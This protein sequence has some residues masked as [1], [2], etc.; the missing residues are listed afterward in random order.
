MLAQPSA[1]TAEELD[2][3]ELQLRKQRRIVIYV[4]DRPR[5]AVTGIELLSPGNKQP[6]AV[7]QQRYLEKRASALHGGLHWV[8]IDLLRGGVRPP[9]PVPPPQSADYLTYV[10]QATPTGWNHLL[11]AWT[12]RD[13]LPLLPIRLLGEDQVQ[14][15]LGRCFAVAYDRIAADDDVDYK[16]AP[17]PPPLRRSDAAWMGRLLRE[18]G[19]RKNKPRSG[20][21]R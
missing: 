20:R 1:S 4:Q 2:A 10:A 8:E 11:Y 21:K 17:P 9:M 19:L 5:L 14:L 16:T 13:P 7:A 18:R 6:G 12:L 3:D 15:D